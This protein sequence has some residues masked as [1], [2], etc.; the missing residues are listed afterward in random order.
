MDAN[1]KL[2]DAK[3][4]FD[5]LKKSVK[6]LD[7]RT[8]LTSAS[9]L[10]DN[11]NNDAVIKNAYSSDK[12]VADKKNKLLD[13]I[14]DFQLQ[15]I[16]SNDTKSC[17]ISIPTTA[18]ID[19]FS[20]AKIELGELITKH[21]T[22]NLLETENYSALC[23]GISEIQRY[24]DAQ[25]KVLNNC[26]SGKYK[27]FIMGEYQSGKST[28]LNAICGGRYISALGDGVA[29]SAV[30]IEVSYSDRESILAHWRNKE[31]FKPI[32]QRIVKFLPDFDWNNFD[33]DKSQS[34]ALLA[35]AL[36]VL[37]QSDMLPNIAEPDHKFL[38]VCDL[39]LKYYQTKELAQR[40]KSLKS[41]SEVANSTRFPAD[42]EVLWRKNG[43][44]KFTLNEAMFVFI[45]KVECFI[46]SSVLKELNCTIIDSPGL[47][48]SAYD[49]LVTEKA[50][51]DAHAIMFLIPYGK[52]IGIDNIGS[53]RTIQE[54]YK[55]V[56]RKLFIVNNLNVASNHHKIANHN[57]NQI[58]E[59]FGESKVLHCYDAKMAYWARLC[60]GFDGGTISKD[61]YAHIMT[62]TE[63]DLFF[64]G[65]TQRKFN[66]FQDAWEYHTTNAYGPVFQRSNIVLSKNNLYKVS[67]L[68]IVLSKLKEF[69]E[70]NESYGVIVS[71]GI[72]PLCNELVSIQNSL[73]QQ[74]VEPFI[75]STTDLEQLWNSRVAKAKS[76]QKIVKDTLVNAIFDSKQGD[77]VCTRIVNEENDKLFT[78]LVYQELAKEIA[79]TLY[80]NKTLLLPLKKFI[81][82]KPLPK[83]VDK[84]GFVSK[85]QEI[86]EPLILKVVNE[87]VSRKVAYMYNM[88]DSNQD[89]TI[90]NIFAPVIDKVEA[91]LE[92]A[93]KEQFRDQSVCFKDYVSL[94]SSLIWKNEKNLAHNA[95]FRQ[96]M[97]GVNAPQVDSTLL[98]GLLAQIGT[99]VGGIA[100]LITS[101]LVLIFCDPTGFSL[102]ASV[103]LAL[104]GGAITLFAPDK[105][106]NKFIKELSEK[107]YEKLVDGNKNGFKDLV[108]H[109]VEYALNAYIESVKVDVA[110]MEANRDVALRPNPNKETD[111]FNAVDLITKIDTQ[112]QEY[113]NFANN[114]VRE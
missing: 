49:T 43:V 111:C 77:S 86:I 88:M 60:D 58:R 28:T 91:Q 82:L 16:N 6:H 54:N 76:F 73:H 101:I 70:T 17:R 34:R 112:L 108:K 79:A 5:L 35:S 113:C 109:H 31:Q 4:K 96:V 2:L 44:A 3:S 105:V 68:E 8:C 39:I 75:A 94:P 93:W 23:S 103:I 7:V 21:Q 19:D 38:M 110:K 53:L 85:L 1:D 9:T 14:R 84:D 74:F 27:V 80:D 45:E 42:G 30:L 67:K 24:K 15:V 48:S 37:R 50:M 107:I 78:D 52:S 18:H 72:V 87:L 46:Q 36:S 10:R 12:V 61:D 41:I 57:A 114:H 99:V 22:E 29:T 13:E 90:Q 92:N 47:F 104:L 64:G 106:R 100:T 56:H 32:F 102:L 81:Q 33:L 83:I 11:I 89:L 63:Y 97:N 51:S 71:N 55:D 40:I 62:V 98:V 69:I 25:G 26:T 95:L 59:M 66:K 20:K 65:E